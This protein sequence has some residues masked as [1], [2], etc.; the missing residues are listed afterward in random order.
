MTK[1]F[2]RLTAL[3]VGVVAVTVLVE[4]SAAAQAGGRTG[5]DSP[6]AQALLDGRKA[7]DSDDFSLAESKFREAISLDPKLND[8]YWRLAAILYGKKKY[9]DAIALLRRAPDPTDV[10]VRE[11]LGLALYKTA[12]PPPAESLKLLEDVVTQRP[13]SYAAQL[14]LGQHLVRTDPKRAAAA[15][16]Q[17][18]KYRPPAAASMDPQI[19]MV[20]GT[21]Y[22]YGHEW[23]L[24]QR[25]FEGLLKTKPN[26]MTAK[27]ML[28]SVFVGKGAC[29]QAIS[30]YE[31]ILGEAQRQPSIY[32][33][34]G[35]CYLRE[36]RA[37][38]AQ[39]EAELYVK[40]KPNE[41]RAHLLV[42]EALY[43][44]RNYNRALSECQAAERLDQ[45]NG[46]IRGKIGRIYLGMR[47]YQ[48]AVTYL[49]QAVAAAKAAGQGR[50]PEILGALAEAYSAMH[51]PKDKLNAIADELASLRQDPKALATAGQVYFLA[52]NDERAATALN[53]ALALEPSNGVARTGLVKVLNRR[54]GVAVEHGE[55]G[56]AY[57]L[58]SDASKLSPEDLMTNRNLGLVLLMAKKYGEAETVLQRSLKKV[59]NDMVVNRMMARALLQQH[60]IGPATA[61]YEKAAQMALR[62][63]GPELAA[64]YAELGPLYT[65]SDKLDQAVSVLE[66]AV[67]EA[68]S[69]PILPV[70]QRN[71]SIAYFKRGMVRL[72]DPKQADNAFD[73]MVAA[74]RA[75]RG[76][77]TN[78]EM[79]AVACGEAL[80][81][82]KANKVQQAE[83]AWD[84]AV[85]SGGDNACQFKPPYDRLGTKFFIAYTQY[86]DSASPT[87]RESA[88][89][90]FTQLASRATGGTAE[91]L[92]ALL[93]S[94]YELLAYDFY[95]RSD[96][97]RAGQFLASAAKVPAKGDRRE[98]EH[99]MAVI[100]LFSGKSPQ[101]EKVFDTLGTRPCE[102][103]LNLGILRDRQG[104]SK[105]ALEL[106]KQAKACGARAPK[107]GEWIDVKERL[108]GANP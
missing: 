10:D 86:R 25:E 28:G 96:E 15:I 106:Y 46:T 62:T 49:E 54:A 9:G 52:G 74:A 98:L 2:L 55:V 32:Y 18:L 13:D 53:A 70:A 11:Q 90:L 4:G 94:G 8:A 87:K 99:N 83:D 31:R 107:L 63:R 59:P 85:K 39:R 6:G 41:S 56:N 84:L 47:N 93:R 82:L 1:R 78:K 12:N 69:T 29:S 76:A 27:L 5:S 81:A 33:N 40:A 20:L 61:A 101:A 95:Q 71:L 17:Y 75:P 51:A 91:W 38:D 50:D 26:D 72:R 92:R 42:C 22:V 37:A 35:T 21:A 73:D 14:Q 3:A 34:L 77:L 68:G 108:F 103:R 24:A 100:D 43:E 88:V 44:Q 58:L 48:A 23:D 57:Q 97:K 66:T 65:E 16:E 60:K 105:K 67:K 80:A 30:L 36:K 104:E 102:A 89:K 7:L 79:A 45:V 64:I 19:H